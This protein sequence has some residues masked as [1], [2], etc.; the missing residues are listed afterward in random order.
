MEAKHKLERKR[1]SENIKLMTNEVQSKKRIKEG[2]KG[3]GER[4]R[5]LRGREGGRGREE[6]VLTLLALFY[7]YSNKLFRN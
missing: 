5:E 3:G 1:V 6:I 2:G 7:Y 4:G